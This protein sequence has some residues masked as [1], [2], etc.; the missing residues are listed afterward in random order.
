MAWTDF[1]VDLKRRKWRSLH[2]SRK[3]KPLGFSKLSL[4]S[5]NGGGDCS[6]G[7]K[8]VLMTLG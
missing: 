5:G 1:W 6:C 3:S 8:M 7:W 4:Y 2:E